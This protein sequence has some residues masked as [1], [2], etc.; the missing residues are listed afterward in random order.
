[1]GTLSTYSKK[2]NVEGVRELLAMRL[3]DVNERDTSGA[4]PLIH[5][6]W[7]NHIEIIRLLLEYGADVNATT[8]RGYSA[9]H[10]AFER[11]HDDLI[12]LLFVRYG[13]DVTARNSLG[14]SPPECAIMMSADERPFPP[15]DAAPVT[16][17]VRRRRPTVLLAALCTDRKHSA[18]NSSAYVVSGGDD[19]V[20][21]EGSRRKTP[22]EGDVT[23]TRAPLHFL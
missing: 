6:A 12:D 5:C 1:V 14:K 20:A 13:A 2:N 3:A 9:L 10:F 11:G 7:D 21:N 18:S 17:D 8:L 22:V 16:K 15:M 23:K 19:V 4:T